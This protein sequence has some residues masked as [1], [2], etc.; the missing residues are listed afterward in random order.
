MT[1]SGR[2]RAAAAGELEAELNRVAGDPR[3]VLDFTGLDYAS[4]AALAAISRF[5]DRRSPEAPGVVLAAA[6]D[7]LRLTLDLA[8]LSERLPVAPTRAAAEALLTGSTTP[9]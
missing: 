2:L 7:A 3:V 1:A 9:R 8:G 4:S 6:G 5:I